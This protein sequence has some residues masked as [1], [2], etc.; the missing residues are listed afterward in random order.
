M[1]HMFSDSAM[2]G[3]LSLDINVDGVTK[4]KIVSFAADS[5]DNWFP[6]TVGLT[7]YQG[8]RVSFTFNGLTG[9]GWASDIAIDQFKIDLPTGVTVNSSPKI[10]SLSLVR[11]G[12]NK[13]NF[14]VPSN[15]SGKKMDI[16]LFNLKG[17]RVATIMKGISKT[18]KAGVNIPVNSIATGLYICRLSIDNHFITLSFVI[19]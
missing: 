8:D 14:A 18:G 13:I 1:C 3:E 6:V 5:G 9:S 10:M 12:A 17:Q 11:N 7:E 15:L 2:M 4:E 16:S 19:K